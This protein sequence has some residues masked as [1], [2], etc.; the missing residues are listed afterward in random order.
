MLLE[1][2][3][4]WGLLETCRRRQVTETRQYEIFGHQT[5][6]DNP[7]EIVRRDAPNRSLGTARDPAIVVEN[8]TLNHTM[9]PSEWHRFPEIQIAPLFDDCEKEIGDTWVRDHLLDFGDSE[10]P[11]CVCHFARFVVD[12]PVTNARFGARQIL[13]RELISLGWNIVIDR[14]RT[15]KKHA[16]GHGGNDN[17]R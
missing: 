6:I 2:K 13:P 12:D 8:A 1:L 9:W 7:I 11:S 14:V 3:R 16:M 10:V 15:M 17:A 4:F 5:Q